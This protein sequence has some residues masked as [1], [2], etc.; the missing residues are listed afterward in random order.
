VHVVP[1]LVMGVLIAMRLAPSAVLLPVLGGP[2]APWSA[3]AALTAM[4]AIAL[5]L[6]QPPEVAAAVAKLPLFGLAAIAVKELAV[7]A[8]L[9]LIASAPFLAADT[10]GRWIGAAVGPLD[11]R[12]AGVAGPTR[13]VGLLTSL[14][15]V[16]VFFAIDGHLVVIG[17]LAQSYDALPLLGGLSR[18]AAQREVLGAVVTLLG[19][20]VAL[21]APSLV[22]A[23][24]VDLVLGLATRGAGA[25]AGGATALRGAVVVAFVGAGLGLLAVAISRDLSTAGATFAN[26]LTRL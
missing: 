5:A 16:L 26:A 11:A 7:G 20:A 8:I 15:A 1:S 17:A 14:I 6:V 2:L 12:A 13:T 25:I 10:A 22:A 21:A 9:A 24:L 19:A 18:Q 3:R 4:A 23:A